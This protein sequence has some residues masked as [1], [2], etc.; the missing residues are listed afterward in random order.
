MLLFFSYLI[1]FL[2]PTAIAQILNH[3]AELVTPIGTPSI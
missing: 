2:I 3:I 1:D